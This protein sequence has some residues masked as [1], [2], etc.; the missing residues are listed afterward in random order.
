MEER[1]ARNLGTAALPANVG[2]R[3]IDLQ[4]QREER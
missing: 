4:K 3:K 2:I 1:E